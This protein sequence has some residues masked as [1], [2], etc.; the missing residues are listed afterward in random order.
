MIYEKENF[1]GI[2]ADFQAKKKMK[3]NFNGKNNLILNG[4]EKNEKEDLIE[5]RSK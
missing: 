4:Y 1:F 3:K 5:Y 2:T